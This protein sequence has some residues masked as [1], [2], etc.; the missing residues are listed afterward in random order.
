MLL[1]LHIIRELEGVKLDFVH[2]AI[3]SVSATIGFI[4]MIAAFF[5]IYSINYSK[6]K[7]RTYVHPLK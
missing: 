6:G 2:Y 7:Q 5:N 1:G 4:I 3:Y